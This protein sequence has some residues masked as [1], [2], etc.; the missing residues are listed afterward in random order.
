MPDDAKS[1][2]AQQARLESRRANWTTWWQEI[3]LRVMPSAA[4]FTTVSAEGERRTE[5]LF[6]GKP[7]TD[8]ERFAA[9]MDDLLT[10]RTQ[11]WHALAPEDEEIEDDQEAA[12][13]LDRLNNLLFTVRYRPKAN[14]AAQKHM[15]YLSVGAFGNSCLFIDEEVARGPRYRQWHMSE[16]FWAENHQGVIDTIYRKFR[17][18]A[19]Q[20]VQKAKEAGWQSLPVKI[21]QTAEKEPFT[22]FEFIHAIQPNPERVASRAD[23]RGMAYSSH[24]VAL[25]GQHLCHVGGYRSFPC[26]IGRYMLGP[27]ETYGRSPAMAAWPGILT[28][29]EEKKTILRAGQKEVDPPI[30][31]AEDGVLGVFN[32]RPGAAN[33]GMVTMDGQALAQP[34]KTGANVPLGLELMGLEAAEI[35]E[36]FLVSIFKILA[37]HPQ[38]T[39]TQVLEITQQKA[40]L[41]APMMGRQQSEDLGP[42][43]E[44]EV[45]ILS[46]DTRF[47]WIEEEMPE[48]LRER[49][50]AYKI[51][52]RSPLARALRAQDGV[53]IM[54]TMEALPIAAQLDP[55]ALLIVDVPGAMRELAAINGMPPKLV[56]D[57]KTV[58]QL[59]Q[60]QREAEQVEAAVDAAPQLSQ[61]ALNA[62]KAEQLRMS[63]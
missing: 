20:A 21:L 31:L 43:I 6:S 57:S 60:Q 16:V 13:Y 24:Y 10:P 4:Q 59:K 63:A 29:N 41:L 33:Y 23:Y 34:M 47:A 18:T 32:Q 25:E 2:I 39:A 14:F 58:E 51:E 30:L 19:K 12:A 62:A 49:M 15:G 46:R 5:R 3:A 22:E 26:A 42:L 38:M 50:A 53:A 52:Y 37:E 9:V 56:R 27:N 48:S 54:R 61:A 45:E 44:R 1:L 55:D 17:L 8:N 7:V 28:L 36:A 35:E 11:K 40:T